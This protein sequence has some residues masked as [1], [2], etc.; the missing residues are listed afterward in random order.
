MSRPIKEK[1]VEKYQEK[2]RGVADVAVVSTKG[3]GV[4]Q[5]TALRGVLRAKG[6]RAMVVHNRLGKRAL[7]TA[8]LAGIAA[9]LKGPS[10]LVWGGD[11]I[12]DIAKVLAAEAKNVQ[13]MEIRGGVTAGVVLSKADIEALSKMPGR[14]ELLGRV[15]GLATGPG[16]RVAG[17]ILSAAARVVAQIRQYEKK[18]AEA[19][20]EAPPE[21]PSAGDRTPV[22]GGDATPAT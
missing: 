12:V 19:A 15:A 7:E 1:I 17:L 2:F 20:P 3:V 22:P 6:I 13:T 8:G 9:L 10:T 11:G 16:S 14:K 4:I 18:A 21:A 5:M